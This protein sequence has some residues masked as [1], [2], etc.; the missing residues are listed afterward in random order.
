[1]ARVCGLGIAEKVVILQFI[2]YKMAS[3]IHKRHASYIVLLIVFFSH[4]HGYFM[5]FGSCY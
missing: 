2:T 1:M 3:G 5:R 4:I